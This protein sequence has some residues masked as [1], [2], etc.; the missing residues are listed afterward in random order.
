M[1]KVFKCQC[2]EA[3]YLACSKLW[4][5]KMSCC[6]Q[7]WCQVYIITQQG[8]TEGFLT[9]LIYDVAYDNYGFPIK[10]RYKNRNEKKA[11]HCILLGTLIH[12]LLTFRSKHCLELRTCELVKSARKRWGRTLWHHRLSYYLECPH[13]RLKCLRLL[14]AS[15]YFLLRHILGGSV[16]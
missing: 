16:I 14:P 7:N 11:I 3:E 10:S 9:L 6:D 1:E 13:L 15:F 5:R 2:I 12:P 8:V 4:G